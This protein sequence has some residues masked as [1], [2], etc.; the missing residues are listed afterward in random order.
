MRQIIFAFFAMILAGPLAACGFTPLYADGPVG[1]GQITVE[2]IDGRAGHA[3]RKALIQ[4]LA[5][6]LPGLEGPATLTVILDEDLKRLAFQADEAATRSDILVEAEYVLTLPET[7]ISGK[8]N[9]ET[10]FLVP[11]AP[12]ADVTAQI[13]ASERASVQLA[14]R[15]VDDL[16]ISLAN[17]K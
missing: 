10:S 1:S 3:L 14:Q 7:A 4:E 5:A 8:A 12:F 11:D 2:Q 9:A 6:G 13:D 16:R 15:I 17:A